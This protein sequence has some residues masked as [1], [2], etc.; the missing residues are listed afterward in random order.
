MKKIYHKYKTIIITILLLVGLMVVAFSLKSPVFRLLL[1]KKIEYYQQG[2]GLD[3]QYTNAYVK[4]LST[5]ELSGISVA[6]NDST[7]TSS[8]AYI[9][10]KIPFNNLIKQ[11]FKPTYI[12]IDSFTINVQTLTI[13]RSIT[14]AKNTV[15]KDFLSSNTEATKPEPTVNKAQNLN[16]DYLFAAIAGVSVIKSTYIDINSLVINFESKDESLNITLDKLTS[17]NGNF[18]THLKVNEN[19]T[20]TEELSISG[21]ANKKK[22]TIALS[23]YNAESKKV[24]IPLIESFY[25]SNLEFDTLTSTLFINSLSRDSLRFENSTCLHGLKMF[26]PKL[27]EETVNIDFAELKL[28]TT[29]T[30]NKIYFDTLSHARVNNL[31]IPFYL[32]VFSNDSITTELKINEKNINAASAFES[33][34]R[35]LFTTIQSVNVRGSLNLELYAYVNLN[36]PENLVFSSK[37]TPQNFEII[38]LAPIDLTMLNDT[39]THNIYQ[40]D[41]IIKSIPVNANYKYF[42]RL[43]HISEHLINAVIISEDGGFYSHKGFDPDGFRYAMARNLKERR[44]ARGGSTITMQLVKNLFLNKHKNLLRK[45]EEA[46]IVWLIETQRLVSKE[47][48]LEIYLNIIEWGPN[49]NGITESS[50]FYFNKE[51]DR[52]ELNEAIFLASIIPRPSKFKYSFDSLGYLRPYMKDYYEFIGSTMFERDMINESELDSLTPSVTLRGNAKYFL[53]A[54]YRNRFFGNID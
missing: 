31:T 47:R 41:S 22:D 38:R 34:P 7:I 11:R 54:T 51:P 5:F 28:N 46:I 30:P 33:L 25:G 29:A 50:E 3:I 48:L 15:S 24:S 18:T 53:D 40:N 23:I 35:E 27:S 26:H 6:N 9:S 45:A 19:D 8:V 17:I 32:S 2:Q 36:K 16:I 42:S 20:S 44:L 43:E 12:K 39:F 37:L 52:I 10:A 13:P 21:I 4:G 1:N 49:I 14:D